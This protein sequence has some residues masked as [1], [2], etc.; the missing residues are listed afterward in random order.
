MATSR[1]NLGPSTTAIHAG[2]RTD[3]TTHALNTPIYQT[4]TF[5]F[6]TA[7]DKEAA[8]DRSLEWQPDVY[9]YT[10]TGN[11]TTAAL[12]R[13]LAALEGAEDATVGSSGMAACSATLLSLL[14]SRRPPRRLIGPVRHHPGAARRRPGLQGHR[15]HPRRR[16]R[17]GAVHPPS[18]RTPK[19]SSSS[20][21]QPP[22]GHR[23]RA[24]ARLRS[25]VNTA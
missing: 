25:P 13:K 17:S 19:S 20:P 23:R 24:R 16:H 2:E 18:A 14:D 21:V 22:H 1:N 5:A 9:F 12:E 15:D 7:E 3:P 4:A 10:R 8:V 6:D 11:P